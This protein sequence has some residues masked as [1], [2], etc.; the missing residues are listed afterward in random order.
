MMHAVT[1]I[2]VVG[3][4]AATASGQPANA[5]G[6]WEL[7]MTWPEA[8][9]TGVCTLKQEGDTL[10][11]TC[12]SA[13]DRF[14]VMGRVEGNRLSWQVNVTQ[15]GSTWRMEFSGELDA[16]GARVSGT[17]SIVDANS[18]TFANSGTFTMKRTG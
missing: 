18:R 8:T 16:Q 17:C 2:L 10:T 3:M 11:G 4:L 1:A 14:P 9:S 15:D 7:Q 13:T 5:S 6:T 12:G